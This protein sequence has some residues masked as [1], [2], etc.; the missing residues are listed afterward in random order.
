MLKNKTNLT[1]ITVRNRINFNKKFQETKSF[2]GITDDNYGA[3]LNRFE[4]MRFGREV[5][6]LSQLA[7][8]NIVKFIHF[9][10]DGHQ[11]K[12]YILLERGIC[13]LDNF[14]VNHLPLLI[15]Q[16]KLIERYSDNDRFSLNQTELIHCME[17]LFAAVRYLHLTANII[18]N[19]LKLE[20]IIITE[21]GILKLI[22]FE[23][24]TPLSNATIVE[25]KFDDDDGTYEQQIKIRRSIRHHIKMRE[26]NS[27]SHHIYR[28]Q[29]TPLASP[30]ENVRGTDI[31]D[32]RLSD[33]WQLG[34]ILY[35]LAF[36]H[37]PFLFQCKEIQLLEIQIS[38]IQKLFDVIENND[39][40]IPT[41]Y[42]HLSNDII[43]LL[44]VM[45]ANK[46]VERPFIHEIV[47]PVVE[48]SSENVLKTFT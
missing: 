11:K 20:N 37:H 17:H 9:S 36:I 7:H 1:K 22:D 14:F 30:P 3:D 27:N 38:Q 16:K 13:D 45:L 35:Q 26:K 39:I 29:C 6:I 32:G 21:A 48:K 44:K 47:I 15:D 33:V 23:I 42:G 4:Q 18:H 10:Y 31:Y 28:Q 40:I 41:N 8:E 12:L 2:D 19:D 25:T 43:K 34:V 24:A 5:S 46:N